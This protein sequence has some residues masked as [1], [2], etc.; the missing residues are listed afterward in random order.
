MAV[1]YS[2]IYKNCK[3]RTPLTFMMGSDPFILNACRFSDMP[4]RHGRLKEYSIGPSKGSTANCV[5]L[6]EPQQMT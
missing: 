6:N 3:L 4:K 2:S 5:K 1:G